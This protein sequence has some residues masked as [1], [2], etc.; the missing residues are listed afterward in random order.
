[1]SIYKTKA[2]D[3]TDQDWVRVQFTETGKNTEVS[4][5]INGLAWG[6]V[7]YKY[8]G[9]AGSTLIIKLTV[10]TPTAPV[11]PNPF[12]NP[13]K[14]SIQDKG[15]SKKDEKMPTRTLAPE[16][17]RG[18]GPLTSALWAQHTPSGIDNPMWEMAQAVVETLNH[19]TSSLTDPCSLCYP[20]SP[21]FY[22]AI[23]I[24]GSYTI[25]N[26][27]P[28][29]WDGRPWRFTIALVS[30][31]GTCVGTVPTAQSQ[32]CSSCNST[33]WEQGKW[34]IPSSG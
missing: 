4:R 30:I 34:I 3:K 6:M 33:P 1:M 21:P 31:A 32:L 17:M 24:N 11:G 25:N 10:S 5:W 9:H 18:P 23:G 12:I 13:Q 16:P 26:S 27:H 19:T 14:P 29:Y 15:L 22:E 2:C 7:Y 28:T 20:G 8:G